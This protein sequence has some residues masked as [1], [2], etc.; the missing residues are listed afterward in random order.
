MKKILIFISSLILLGVMSYAAS[1]IID[2]STTGDN[3]GPAIATGSDTGWIG[4]RLNSLFVTTDSNSVYFCVTGSNI[5]TW[6]AGAFYIYSPG[7]AA[8]T[9]PNETDQWSRQIKTNWSPNQ[10]NVQVHLKLDNSWVE[11]ALWNGSS[12]E[13]TANTLPHGINIGGGS[14]NGFEVA[15][16]KSI[17]KLTG[18]QTIQ[19][20]ALITGDQNYHGC[21]DSIP[22]GVNADSWDITSDKGDGTGPNNETVFVSKSIATTTPKV[23]N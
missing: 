13:V 23:K 4:V 15:I 6:E 20:E 3:Y 22:N 19:A 8:F 11:I 21:F 5:T 9:N 1:P 18:N 10:P 7:I 16:P 14:A 17:L 2:G 12:W